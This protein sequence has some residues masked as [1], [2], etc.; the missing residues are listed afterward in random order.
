[1]SFVICRKFI[2]RRLP[3]LH[4]EPAEAIHG[5]EH[6]EALMP[7]YPYGEDISLP[8]DEKECMICLMTV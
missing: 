6:F 4:Y 2:Q 1:V 5:I 3:R 8:E 7:S